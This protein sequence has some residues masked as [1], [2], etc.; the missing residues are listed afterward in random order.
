MSALFHHHLTNGSGGTAES[1]T[2]PSP[3]SEITKNGNDR[4]GALRQILQ[5][6]SPKCLR[7]RFPHVHLHEDERCALPR[8][9]P[10]ID[11]H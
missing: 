3:A 6:S 1:R 7:R 10:A 4:D 9:A 11:P 5:M 2:P 8:V